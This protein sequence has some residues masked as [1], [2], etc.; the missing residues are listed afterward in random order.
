MMQVEVPGLGSP[1]A[2]GMGSE[3]RFADAVR[4]NYS[5]LATAAAEESGAEASK[6]QTMV[7]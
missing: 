6:L 7:H 5:L 4:H 1:A 2:A 3:N